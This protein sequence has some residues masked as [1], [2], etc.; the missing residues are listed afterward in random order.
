MRAVTGEGPASRAVDWAAEVEESVLQAG[1]L[2]RKA[3]GQVGAVEVLVSTGRGP[4]AG[5]WLQVRATVA[6]LAAAYGLRVTTTRFADS[7]TIRI[8]ADAALPSGR[9]G[10]PSAG[11]WAWL[12]RR[13][14]RVVGRRDGG[15]EAPDQP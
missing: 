1:A 10:T 2:I 8:A 14:V 7:I 4:S 12:R 9:S 15:D 3:D 5:E 11:R 6:E 13:L